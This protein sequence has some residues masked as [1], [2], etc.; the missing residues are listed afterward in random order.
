MNVT[1][2]LSGL[3]V[4]SK[5]QSR[6]DINAPQC[7]RHP[8]VQASRV[9]APDAEHCCQ[10]NWLSG[11]ACACIAFAP[12]S[13]S[14]YNVRLEDVENPALQSGVLAATQHRW[15]DAEKQFRIVLDEEPDSAS[16]W[17]NL[18]NVHLSKGRP[19]EAFR[20]FSEAVRL[21]PTA[22]VPYLNRALAEEQ[23]GVDADEH[24]QHQEAQVQYSGAVK[25]CD[26]AIERDPKEF[27]A[28]FNRGNALARLQD[29]NGA[30][31]SYRTAADLAPGIAGYRL[32]EAE[33]LFQ[34]DRV[35]D[36]D[37]LLRTVLRKN[38]TY[39]EAHAAL[40]AVQWQLGQASKAEE[41]FAIATAIDSRWKRVSYIQTQM[42][43]PPKLYAAMEKF[44]SIVPG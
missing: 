35:A 5:V 21:A 18:G 27:A 12:A 43:W 13:V 10:P 30:L 39:A 26:L 24:N 36:S 1:L 33:L 4:A 11:L 32:R 14:A 38:P 17:S 22:P 29:Y 23:L 6:K 3:H 42:R 31:D 28:W 7:C 9:S 37:R 40:T 34:A 16:A 19:N 8:N 41:H 2:G 15:D 20:D 25:D 44:L